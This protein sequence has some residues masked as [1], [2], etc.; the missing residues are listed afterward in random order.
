M[1]FRRRPLTCQQVVELVTEYL[2]GVMEPRRRAR[3]EAHLA[4][5]DGCTNYLE[6][7]RTTV[8]VVGRLDAGDVPEP[9]MSDLLSAFRHWADDRNGA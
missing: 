2:D 5:C 9:V 8:A 1:L 4:G 7:F 3:F 6:Q